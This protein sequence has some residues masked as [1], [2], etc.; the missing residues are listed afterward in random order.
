MT[1]SL[2]LAAGGTVAVL[3]LGG[4]LPA[5]ASAD[6]VTCDT[7]D[8]ALVTARAD[9]DAAKAERKAAHRPLGKLVSEK[10]HEARAELSQ[11]RAELKELTK[12]ARKAKKKE[13]KALQ[14][15]MRA[16]R[17][18]I[19]ESHRLLTV[20]RELLAAIQA[21]RA[22]ARAA[23]DV[24]RAHLHDL[25]QLRE[26]CESDSEPEPGDDDGEDVEPEP[27]DT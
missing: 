11:S 22:A 10:R 13:L 20:K 7:V 17:S 14:R 9:L 12:E 25:K 8:A 27:E 5:A 1:L 16:E 19:A 24:A 18:D 15:Q 3:A 26:S 4:L 21:D 6:E 23:E 2:R